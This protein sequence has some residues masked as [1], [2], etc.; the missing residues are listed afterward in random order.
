MDTDN[1]P[2]SGRPRGRPVGHSG[3]RERE[4]AIVALLEQHPGGLTRNALATSLKEDR[5]LVWLALDRLRNA[6]KVRTCAP[7]QV[8]GKVDGKVVQKLGRQVVWSLGPQCPDT[9]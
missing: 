6:G 2:V 5:N 3:A 7:I 8:V 1:P 9:E 4:D